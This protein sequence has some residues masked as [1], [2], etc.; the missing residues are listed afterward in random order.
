MKYLCYRESDAH[1]PKLF[2]III[3]HQLKKQDQS[4]MYYSVNKFS[5]DCFRNR[6]PIL[7]LWPLFDHF[8]ELETS[9]LELETALLELKTPLLKLN[10][11]VWRN[12][13]PACWNFR[14]AELQTSLLKACWN[15]SYACRNSRPLYCNS[16]TYLLEAER[17][18]SELKMDLLATVTSLEP[19]SKA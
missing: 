14:P 10:W 7:W 18:L 19:R 3:F 8:F 6:C 2:F 16:N 4:S 17:D 1:L 11:L 9:L 15:S 12:S 5:N 13:R